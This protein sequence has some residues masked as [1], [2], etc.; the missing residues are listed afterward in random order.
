MQVMKGKNDIKELEVGIDDPLENPAEDC[1]DRSAFA[2]RIFEIIEGTPL[3]T[4]MTIGIHGA[5]GSGK[6]TTMN[7]L[8]FYCKEAGHPVALYTPWQFHDKKEAWKGFVSSI[9][10]GIA[11]WQGKKIGNLK[12]QAFVKQASEKVRELTAVTTVGKIAGSLILAPLEG[13]LE[14]TKQKVQNELNK[15]LKDKR[16]FIFIDDLDRADPDILYDHL[17]L[18]NEIVNLNRCVYVIGLDV[19][20]A[21][22]VLKNKIGLIDSKEFLEKIINWSFSLPLPTNFEWQELLDKEIENLDKN[23]KRDALCSIFSCLPKNPR[24]FKHF[25]RYISA[26]HK[27]FLNRFDDHEL[28]WELLYLAQLIRL[29]FSEVLEKIINK[30]ELLEYISFGSL[31]LNKDKN[32][33]LTQWLAEISKDVEENKKGRLTMLCKEMIKSV[34][35]TDPEELKNHFLVIE[36]PELFT[37]KEYY[38]FKKELLSLS[39]TEITQKITDFI[40]RTGKDK[41]IERIREFI[42]ML[43][44]DREKLLS[45]VSEARVLEEMK[46]L[47][48]NTKD[49]VRIC[50]LLLDIDDIFT[51]RNPIFNPDIFKTWYGNI[52]GWSHFRSPKEIYTEIRHLDVELAK[53][54]ALKM[55]SQ[56]S[57]IL[58]TFQFDD[59][60]G[61]RKSFEATHKEI[62]E[63]LEKAVVGQILDRFRRSYGIKELWKGDRPY[64]TEKRLLFSVNSL[65]HNEKVYNQLKNITQE[66]SKN[67][68]IHENF[69]EY[70]R[71]LFFA[72]TDCLDYTDK[73]EVIK[74][75]KEKV[76]MNIIWSVVVSKHLNLRVVGTFEQKRKIIMVDLLKDENAFPVP[77]WWEKELKDAKDRN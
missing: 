37:W 42:K 41:Q 2:K 15:V 7:F 66:V 38:A 21:S 12:R 45:Q 39:N 52:V 72:A 8:R 5:W 16:L 76:F 50:F 3:S 18:L 47:I 31:S 34:G 71:A 62:E 6:T 11:E 26:L 73:D 51:G 59:P 44:R 61:S 55:S 60:L 58:E 32:S 64:R 46:P 27:S 14:Q 24:K 77:E 30:K 29:E 4:N 69:C 23:V 22:Q 1:L 65:F 33:N 35:I 43:F 68:D 53:K 74:L 57:L 48:N 10:K 13:L 28:N 40:K 63:I 19:E 36:S 25:L 56:A 49:I 20:V 67:N 70:V 17:M 54:L 9:D 75:L